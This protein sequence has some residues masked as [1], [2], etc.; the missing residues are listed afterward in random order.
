MKSDVAR[1]DHAVE[2]S[3]QPALNVGSRERDQEKQRKKVGEHSRRDEQDSRAEDEKRIDHLF[4]GS[5]PLT[6]M[7]KNLSDRP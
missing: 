3:P 7:A 4:G 6:E 2:F 5:N 1:G